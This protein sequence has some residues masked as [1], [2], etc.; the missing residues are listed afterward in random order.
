MDTTYTNRK[1][2][3]FDLSELTDK[4]R[5]FLAQAQQLVAQGVAWDAFQNFYLS[6]KSA[7]WFEGGDPKAERLATT[8]VTRSPLYR[9]LQDMAGNLG[10]EQGYLRP[11]GS[12]GLG[13]EVT[14]EAFREG[15]NDAKRR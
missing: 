3:V 1:G 9:I 14:L 8:K 5:A 15:E 13:D 12:S 7:V 6:K 11:G 2:E 4:Q 10:V